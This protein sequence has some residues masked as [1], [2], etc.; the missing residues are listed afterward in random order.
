M[1]KECYIYYNVIRKKSFFPKKIT[2]VAN[3]RHDL[4]ESI[5]KELIRPPLVKNYISL[6]ID[7][8]KSDVRE[9][10]ERLL[11]KKNIDFV[12]VR[13]LE[14]TKDEIENY[15][16]YYADFTNLEWGK[17]IEYEFTEPTCKTF[18]PCPWGSKIASPVKIKPKYTRNLDIGKVIDIWHMGQRFVIS[19]K[20]KRIFELEGVTGLKY[21]PC[22]IEQ[23]D[24]KELPIESH[25]DV[26][27]ITSKVTQFGSDI[28]LNSYCKKHNVIFSKT[29]FDQITHRNSITKSDFQMINK[30]KVK[31][32]EYYYRVPLWFVSRKVLKILFDNIISNIRQRGIYF[33]DGLIPVL[34]DDYENCE[35]RCNKNNSRANSLVKQ[36]T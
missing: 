2:P 22:I 21:E 16:Y 3:I 29:I 10:V 17:H 25:F 20:L 14:A 23:G 5:A 27:E 8:T 34:F 35:R 19:E 26:A 4:P 18:E 30:I 36:S 28:I 7:T 1:K 9:Y 11:K 13:Y 6:C 33:K 31:G 15:D 12:R 32:R 24:K